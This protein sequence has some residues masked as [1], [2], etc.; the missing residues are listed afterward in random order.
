MQLYVS[1]SVSRIGYLAGR[2][3]VWNEE[4][5]ENQY[6][7]ETLEG[8]TVFGRPAMTTPFILEMLKHQLDIQLFSTDGHY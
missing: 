8:I 2:V 7:I 5:G 3:T 1:D 4:C 6:P